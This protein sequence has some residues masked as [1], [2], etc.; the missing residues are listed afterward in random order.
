MRILFCVNWEVERL[1]APDPSR[2]SPNYVVD[3]E[4]YWFF[5]HLPRHRDLEVDVLDCRSFLRIDRYEQKYARCYP[6][7]ATLAWLRSRKYDVVLSHG[8]QMGLV[9]G[10]LQSL[11]PGSARPPHVMFD[12]SA[13]TG[14]DG[15]WNNK[16]LVI[17]GCRFAVKS[18]AGAICHSSL[19]LDFYR[20]QFPSVAKV[21]HFIPVGVD[22]EAFRPQPTELADEILCVGY[23]KR[24]WDLLV[25]AYAGL[26]TNTRLVL[27]GVPEDHRISHP[28]VVCVPKVNIDEMRRYVLR[29]RFVVLPLPDVTYCVGQQTFLQSMAMAKTVVVPK[30]PAVVDYVD[31]GET[32]ALYDVNDESDL[33][34]KLR[35]LISDQRAVERMGLAA[36]AAAEGRF[37]EEVMASRVVSLLDE[38]VENSRSN[39]G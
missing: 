25:R 2:F 20:E 38:I 34:T 12:V 26:Q 36:R 6:T 29:S 5:K 28:G 23:A 7:K 35:G 11:S 18:V 14:G 3:G 4:P 33:R 9:I 32:G 27:L 37:R 31:D 17:Q 13:I 10:L 15:G 24:N 1:D 19:H 8:A 30:I 21:A 39:A 16:P 22:T